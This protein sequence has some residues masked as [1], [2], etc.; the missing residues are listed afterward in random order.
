MVAESTE[1]S[2]RD[3]DSFKVWIGSG[4]NHARTRERQRN[5][6]IRG[7]RPGKSRKNSPSRRLIL[8]A[9]RKQNII[10]SMKVVSFIETSEE[11]GDCYQQ[12]PGFIFCG[13]REKFRYPTS[14]DIAN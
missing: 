6:S 9:E 7:E 8:V 11:P 13:A 14:R 3:G 2:V 1:T 12:S 4:S 5:S 10:V